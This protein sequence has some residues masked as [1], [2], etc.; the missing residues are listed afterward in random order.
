[1][2]RTTFKFTALYCAILAY[3]S[4]VAFTGQANPWTKLPKPPERFTDIA[5]NEVGIIYVKAKT[6]TVY[7]YVLDNDFDIISPKNFVLHEW[8][9]VDVKGVYS[10][11]VNLKDVYSLNILADYSCEFFKFDWLTTNKPA[12]KI[13]CIK[14]S[15]LLPDQT[16][17]MVVI[18]D[19]HNDV[20]V[21]RWTI[22]EVIF[23]L[24]FMPAGL[25]GIL[26][27]LISFVGLL[28]LLAKTVIS[29]IRENW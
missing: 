3:I 7:E 29:R 28:F 16:A 17:S 20:W 1:M 4:W 19:E 22:F 14:G 13:R 15:L 18:V 12:T 23:P 5:V 9:Q 8:R 2:L 24:L 25:I 26:A 27:L 6:G 11:K 10:L 21:W